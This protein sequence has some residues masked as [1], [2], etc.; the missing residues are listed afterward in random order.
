MKCPNGQARPGQTRSCMVRSGHAKLFGSENKYTTFS[1]LYRSYLL[2]FMSI[3]PQSQSNYCRYTKHLRALKHF[4]YMS[5]HQNRYV[6]KFL[7]APPF[8][9]T[10][11][12]VMFYQ[13]SAP[14][15][16]DFWGSLSIK[17]C[18]FLLW[19]LKVKGHLQIVTLSSLTYWW[20]DY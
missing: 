10:N 1:L 2:D 9:L 5:A 15:I 7:S 16:V 12:M 3:G 13:W 6:K 19:P 8:F 11:S 17:K 14:N 18:I 4:C 20:L